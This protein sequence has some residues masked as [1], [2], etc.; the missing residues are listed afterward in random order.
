MRNITKVCSE[1]KMKLRNA[2]LCF[3]HWS[4]KIIATHI[5]LA[6][7][8]TT[9]ISERCSQDSDQHKEKRTHQPSTSLLPVSY[10]ID[11]EVLLLV[12]KALHNVASSYITDYLPSYLIPTRTL[13]S[14]SVFL[15]KVPKVPHKSLD[16]LLSVF[17]GPKL[18]NMLVLD[19]RMI[20]SL[21][22]FKRKLKT[23]LL[24]WLSISNNSI[25]C[26]CL[27]GLR[28]SACCSFFLFSFFDP[29]LC[30]ALWAAFCMESAI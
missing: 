8:K 23:D 19:V 1:L 17:Y 22:T 6:S 5:S 4:H 13:R 16:R 2:H 28:F 24:I 20:N 10:G 9:F 29:I 14:S 15:L 21:G 26:S 30:E 27:F 25:I 7:F 3:Y 12:Y 18:W 11:F